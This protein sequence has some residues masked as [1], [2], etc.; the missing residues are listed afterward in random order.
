MLAELLDVQFELEERGVKLWA[1]ERFAAVAQLAATGD[2]LYRN[3]EYVEAKN[4]Y[5][6]GLQALQTLRQELPLELA[7]QLAR[8][9][10]ALETGD[11]AA[12]TE[13]LD[14]AAAIDPENA[15]LAG[16]RK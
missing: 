1:P 14:Y 5:Q 12:A 4:R 16:L 8:A 9:A 13:A 2:E 11:T 6:E 7:R 3:R 15:E 10:E